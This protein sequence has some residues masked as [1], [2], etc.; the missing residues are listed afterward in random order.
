MP[1][2]GE[3]FGIVFIEAMAC[4]TPAIGLAVG[5]ASDALADGELGVCVSEQEFPDALEDAIRHC[6]QRPKQLSQE[7]NRRFGRLS[8]DTAVAEQIRAFMNEKD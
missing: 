5:G 7:V 6:R 8:F 2:T 1:S 4:G 3:G